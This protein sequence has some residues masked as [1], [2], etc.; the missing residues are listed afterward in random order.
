MRNRLVALALLVVVLAIL[1]GLYLILWHAPGY[2]A[3]YAAAVLGFGGLGIWL[4]GRRRGNFARW[5]QTFQS[6]WDAEQ[7][8]QRHA[9]A[10]PDLPQVKRRVRLI[11]L[12]AIVTGVVLGLALGIAV[13]L[14][15]L[16]V[17]G[18]VFAIPLAAFVA[19][20]WM[21]VT[22]RQP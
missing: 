22:G 8:R 10:N 4:V 9:R 15:D 16:R 5:A 7:T 1:A 20:I 21:I 14:G 2:A 13:W 6:G 12:G 17:Y 11:G 19:G 18:W 3:L